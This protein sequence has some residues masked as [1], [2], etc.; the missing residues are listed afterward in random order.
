MEQADDPGG[1]Q[2]IGWREWVTLPELGVRA[3][4]PKID[5]GARSSTIHAHDVAT[6]QRGNKTYVRFTI[7]PYQRSSKRAVVAEAE[8]V[9]FRHVKSSSGHKSLRPVIMTEIELL[10]QRWEIELTLAV[11]D[12]MGFRMLLGRQA[13]RGRF[14]IN[15][16]RSYLGGRKKDRLRETAKR[17]AAAVSRKKRSPKKRLEGP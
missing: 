11:R 13:L 6:F 14:V 3:I 10:G 16:G 7:H 2:V 15:P 12:Q 4:K 5:T 8:V 1:L 17:K 9:E